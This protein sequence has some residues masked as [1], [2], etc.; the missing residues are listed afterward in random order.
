MNKILSRLAAASVALLLLAAGCSSDND[1]A[2]D[3]IC[4][5]V[6]NNDG[7][8]GVSG[9]GER[10][11]AAEGVVH[12]FRGSMYFPLTAGTVPRGVSVRVY[13]RPSDA[14]PSSSGGEGDFVLELRNGGV[15]VFEKRFRVDRPVLGLN[16]L[17]RTI[18]D[19]DKL[20]VADF[21]RFT[22]SVVEPP[23]YDS[24][25]VLWAGRELFIAEK[26]P[27]APS[28]EI[29]G[30]SEDQV[31]GSGDVIDLCLRGIDDD[32]DELTYR[33]FSS[34]DEGVTYRLY[35]GS[36]LYPYDD[37]QDVDS[38][39]AVIRP[40]GT[41]GRGLVDRIGVAVS[42]GASSVFVESPSFRVVSGSYGVRITSPEKDA[43]LSAGASVFLDARSE[44]ASGN[45]EFRW[46]SSLDGDL[47]AG[48]TVEL[49]VG[50]LAVGEHT[51]TVTAAEESL[52]V[53]YADSVRFF[54]IPPDVPFKAFDDTVHVA[55]G[56]LVQLDVRRND[57]QV[58]QP[59][60]TR[61]LE[62]TVP[63]ELGKAAASKYGGSDTPFPVISYISRVSGRDSFEYEVCD[64][65]SF[66]DTATVHV[67]VG[68]DDCTISGT[69]EDDTLVGTQGDDIICALDGNDTIEGLGGDD[70][71]RGGAG[72][73]TIFG[74][75]GDDYIQGETGGDTIHGN[76]GEDLILGGE[77]SDTLYGGAGYDTLGGGNAITEQNP[78]DK[79]YYTSTA[80]PAAYPELTTEETRLLDTAINTCE[81]GPVIRLASEVPK[82]NK[83]AQTTNNSQQTDHQKQ[84]TAITRFV[85]EAA[86]LAQTIAT[87]Y[88][89]RPYDPY[90]D[91]QTIELRDT[92]K[93]ETQTLFTPLVEDNHQITETTTAKLRQLAEAIHDF[94][95]PIYRDDPHPIG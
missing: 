22:V 29:L 10:S 26:S 11:A 14:E 74:G 58:S 67:N 20:S 30:V 35:T 19:G 33:I 16:V 46:R 5:G 86:D 28:V 69:N 93:R 71:I 70:I 23:V 75:A 50:E 36:S 12:V 3:D 45:V 25:S 84:R 49:P 40:G 48:G 55:A 52:G 38:P 87:A 8:S 1:S 68:L 44:I 72:D 47:G 37:W 95:V 43:V 6:E 73:D 4:V 18:R 66:C 88:Q 42:D 53:S 59:G 56:E 65:D 9:V 81:A 82:N 62:V 39:R 78:G 13:S 77:G 79:L 21:K 63:A 7:A 31:F 17:P 15:G 60:R 34:T 64:R 76:S 24:F 90:P 91:S 51:I 85:C 54:V 92:L 61:R 57:T 2:S 41:P 27:S 94:A 83:C 80:T 32:G 89:N